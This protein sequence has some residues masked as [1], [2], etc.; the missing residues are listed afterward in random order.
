MRIIY[1][2]RKEQITFLLQGQDNEF[3]RK[4]KTITQFQLY[5]RRMANDRMLSAIMNMK[6]RYKYSRKTQPKI[7]RK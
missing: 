6:T 2:K 1:K 4:Y 7:S 5:V 3:L